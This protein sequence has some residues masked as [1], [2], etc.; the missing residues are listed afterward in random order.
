MFILLSLNKYRKFKKALHVSWSAE[1]AYRKDAPNWSLKNPAV[2]QCAITA[3]LFQEMFGGKIY[4]G[5]SDTGIYHYWNKCFGIKFDLTKQQF[6]QKYTFKNVKE[7]N[8][9]ELLATGN[10]KE[11]YDI[12]RKRVLSIL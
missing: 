6:S 2:G 10:V 4:S 1:T 3:L 5:V 8:R 11:R 12:L 7:W 9:E